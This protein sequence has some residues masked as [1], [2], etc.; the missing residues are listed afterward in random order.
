MC[1][2]REAAALVHRDAAALVEE[3]NAGSIQLYAKVPEA[4]QVISVHASHRSV[5]PFPFV[6][7][8]N[9]LPHVA[10]SMRGLQFLALRQEDLRGLYKSGANRVDSFEEGIYFDNDGKAH[11]FHASTLEVVYDAWTVEE[12][13]LPL[14]SYALYPF[15]F[16]VRKDNSDRL[17]FPRL[18]E[19]TWENVYI[20]RTDIP[21]LL[22]LSS[23]RR[24]ELIGRIQL[25]KGRH[26]SPDLQALRELLLAE[27]AAASEANGDAPSQDAIERKLI[28]QFKFPKYR[29]V[30]GALVLRS[31]LKTMLSDEQA[32]LDEIPAILHL[33]DCA[34]EFWGDGFDSAAPR[35]SVEQIAHWLARRIELY[36]STSKGCV[37]LVRPQWA[38]QRGRMKTGPSG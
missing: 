9:A 1:P 32:A 37:A 29:A 27:F 30:P 5:S 35:P 16:D 33:F 8:P 17:Q 10:F 11:H 3:A 25:P 14:R 2:L 6:K 24:A 13:T 19:V 18:I 12:L 26:I 20:K 21:R 38:K 22:P 36:D 15:E 34:R 4:L 7:S 28:G 23:N 31:S